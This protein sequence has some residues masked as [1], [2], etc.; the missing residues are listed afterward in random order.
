MKRRQLLKSALLPALPAMGGALAGCAAAQSNA[1]RSPSD[2][3][4]AEAL[5]ADVVIVGAGFAGLSAA[6]T[7][8]RTGAKTAVLEKRAYAGGDGILSV[9]ILASSYSGVHKAL[10]Y[11]GHAD[12]EDYW[13]MIESGKTDEPLA[14]VRDN[15][16]N[17]PIYA[18][19]V[20][21][22][23]RVLRRSAENSAAVADFVASFGIE[24]LPV[25]PSQPF[26]L[27][28]KPGSMPKFA[29]AMLEEAK[30]L[31]VVLRTGT[32]VT[33]LL[34][35][36]EAARDGGPD[37]VG[38]VRVTGV[39]AAG[40]SGRLIVRAPA[41]ILA[42]GG[43]I[44]N[45]AYLRRYKRVWTS[46]PKGFTA[47]G[48]GVPPGHDGDGIA[49]GR[50]AGAAI[51]DMESMPKLFAAPKSGE[52]SPS[53]ILFDTDTAYLVDKAGRRFCDEH[54]SRY[55]GCALECFRQKLS[56]G[57][58]VF[59]EATF[60]GPNAQ[61]WRYA[62]LLEEKGLFRGETV[63]EAAERAGVDPK[64]LRETVERINRDAAAGRGDT[65]FGRRDKL[66]RAL[67][68]P[69]YVSTAS[70]PVMFKTEGGLE[71]DPDFRVL[72]A[73]DD[74]P[75]PGLYA[76]GSN[77][78]SISTRLCDVIASGLIAGPAAAAFARGGAGEEK[79]V[80]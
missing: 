57:Y 64:G 80:I 33:R 2:A 77:C 9:G 66:F 25:N 62:A 71:V 54:A 47:V 4:D 32:R 39:E 76:A 29:Q 46:I 60:T 13:S 50:L 6:V 65:A 7:A 17:S 67:R 24:F 3:A 34:T 58:V 53:W 51:E 41:V 19:F 72:R 78:G 16:P 35:E 36:A 73:A 52:R 48:E 45:A 42:A 11:K 22:D 23:P 68:G 70:S 43:F 21:H 30:R 1:S 15:M 74:S 31:G 49:M 20:K 18:G 55:A 75:I 14:K 63:E 8:A 10:G 27:A 44:D 61:R 38:R 37:A 40:K 56:G 12:L 26:L 5:E 69:F 59:D 79:P 28:S